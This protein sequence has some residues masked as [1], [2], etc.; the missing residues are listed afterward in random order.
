MSAL[1][2]DTAAFLAARDFLLAHRTDYDGAYA[3][4][5]AGRA[6][7][8]ST[9]RSTTSTRWRRATIGRRSGS[10][11]TTAS[12]RSYSFAELAAPQQPGRQ[13]PARRSARGAAT[14]CCSCC[15]TSP[16]PGRRCSPA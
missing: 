8:A 14:G 10:S 15:P 16:R 12:D 1:T 2:S 7:T 3:A 11:A 5:S 9:G 6:S 13:R 4:A